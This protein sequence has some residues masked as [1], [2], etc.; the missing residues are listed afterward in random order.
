MV[1][2]TEEVVRFLMTVPSLKCRAMLTRAYAAGL[3]ASEDVSL[4][5]GDIDGSW[6]SIRINQGKSGQDRCVMLSSQ[7]FDVLRAYWRP[8][9]TARLVVPASAAGFGKRV[10]VLRSGTASSPCL[11]VQSLRYRNPDGP[12]PFAGREHRHPNQLSAAR[13]SNVNTTARHT[14]VA[15]T[16]IGGTPSPFDHL[17]LEVTP[18]S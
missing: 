12:R 7:L 6:L 10:T 5:V 9:S 15:T 1:L 8:A 3:R 14:Q 16:T 17:R 18:P 11:A 13:S 4:K 2:S